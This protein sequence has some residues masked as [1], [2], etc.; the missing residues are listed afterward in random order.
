MRP[1]QAGELAPNA[2]N[3]LIEARESRQHRRE[4]W[5]CQA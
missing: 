5:M 3:P 4:R 2:G 1:G